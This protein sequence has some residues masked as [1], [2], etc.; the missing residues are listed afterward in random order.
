MSLSSGNSFT[1][2][3]YGDELIKLKVDDEIIDQVIDL[4]TGQPMSA[5]VDNQG[6]IAS[7]GGRVALTAATARLVVDNVINND[8]I[9]EAR[10]VG[11]QNGK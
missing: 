10:T 8:G 3:L 9:I 5:L 6:R 2:D 4:A 7:D 1:L 11:E